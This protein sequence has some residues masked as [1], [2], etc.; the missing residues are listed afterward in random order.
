M[1]HALPAADDERRD[2]DAAADAGGADVVPAGR[3]FLSP[4]VRTVLKILFVGTMLSLG[5]WAAY[6][7]LHGH[8][9]A[10]VWAN[11][12]SVPLW[13]VAAALGLT[14][15]NYLVLA[16]Y[17]RMALNYVGK[18]LSWR[19][20]LPTSFMAYA[21]GHALGLP[22]VTAAG[23]RMRYYGAEGL[24][25]GDVAKVVAFTTVTF[26]GGLL[27]LATVIFAAYPPRWP[28]ALHVPTWML[29]TRGLAGVFAL[30]LGAY[31][32]WGLVWRKP[33]K[34]SGKGFDPPSRKTVVAQLAISSAD[35]VLA[36]G[37]FATLIGKASPWTV[38]GV[39]VMA[40]IA[41]YI[42]HVPAGVGVF[43][44][45]SLSLLVRGDL[46]ADRVLAVL[47]IYRIVF[48]LVPLVLAVMLVVVEEVHR[49]RKRHRHE[50][51]P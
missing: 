16:V 6:K 4:V 21:L 20:I 38:A 25:P 13:R 11:F 51:R 43:E 45:V 12:K 28:P 15:A 44:A 29:S 48:Y 23:V 30:L 19:K 40:A 18:P 26:V 41:S 1:S 31:L 3:A 37:V 46:S 8:S 36:V 9:F 22:A 24:T 35:W 17:D 2:R 14:A 49:S 10:D 50:A 7:Q 34:V 47:L 27:I 42:S 33:L 39:F 5:V 32:F